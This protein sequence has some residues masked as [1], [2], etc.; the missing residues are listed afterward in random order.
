MAVARFTVGTDT[1]RRDRKDSPNVEDEE[2]VAEEIAPTDS[3]NGEDEEEDVSDPTMV[4]S[5]N[6]EVEAEDA[7][8]MSR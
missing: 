6:V 3:P 4:S 7:P 5:T 1:F 8:P 2:E